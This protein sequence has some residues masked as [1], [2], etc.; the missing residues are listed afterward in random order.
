MIKWSSFNSSGSGD[1]VQYE[2][3]IVDLLDRIAQLV[4]GV[5]GGDG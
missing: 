2:G 1:S 4:R 3:F 5:E